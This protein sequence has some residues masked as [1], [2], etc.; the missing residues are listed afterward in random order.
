[1]L[2]FSLLRCAQAL[3]A[4]TEMQQMQG[5]GHMLQHGARE[6][7]H[8]V[9]SGV[10]RV[11]ARPVLSRGQQARA[12]ACADA[13]WAICPNPNRA[14]ARGQ[15]LLWERRV[16]LERAAGEALGATSGGG[17]E[18]AALHREAARLAGRA[19]EAGRAQERLAAE[20]ARAVDKRE[21]ILAKASPARPCW[22][23]VGGGG[24]GACAL[25]STEI[26]QRLLRRVAPASMTWSTWRQT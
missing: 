4:L 21:A 8:S 5:L 20:L 18:G 10:A 11:C 24:G 15:A 19:A 6:G 17:A 26:P 3:H 22:V 7:K 2:G 14:C 16:Q 13:P 9:A 23:A 12:L 1:M 25:S